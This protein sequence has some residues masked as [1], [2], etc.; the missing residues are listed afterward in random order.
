FLERRERRALT[1]LAPPGRREGSVDLGL[2]RLEHALEDRVLR[3]RLQRLM[4]ALSPRAVSIGL[5]AALQD[6]GDV[7][8]VAEQHVAEEALRQPACAALAARRLDPP[9]Q[10]LAQPAID[11]PAPLLLLEGAPVGRALQAGRAERP[12]AEG[13]GHA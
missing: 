8:L 1:G 4:Q 10:Q 3:E 12:A 13:L 6:Q 11:R 9:A 2:R 5:E 7:R